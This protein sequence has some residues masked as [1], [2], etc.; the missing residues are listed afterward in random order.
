MGSTADTLFN[1]IT[2]LKPGH[3]LSS[4]TSK[5]EIKKYYQL[6]VKKKRHRQAELK[7]V[8]ESTFSQHFRSDVPVAIALSGGIDSGS[9]AGF[10][11]RL[12]NNTRV[13]CFTVNP[14]KGSILS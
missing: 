3:L 6:S 12:Q 9:I 11:A 13:K 7:E 5:I 8:V 4:V 2:L 1:E 10:A 14:P